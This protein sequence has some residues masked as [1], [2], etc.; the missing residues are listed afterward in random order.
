MEK[1]DYQKFYRERLKLKVVKP[2][3]GDPEGEFKSQ[4][5][6]CGVEGRAVVY[7]TNGWLECPACGRSTLENICRQRKVKLPA[8]KPPVAEAKKPE[9]E[10]EPAIEPEKEPAVKKEKKI[11]DQKVKKQDEQ[12]ALF[13]TLFEG[14]KGYLEIRTISPDKE[15]KQ[16]YYKPKELKRLINDL[17][18][19]ENTNIYFGVCPRSERKGDEAHIKEIRALWVDLDTG[20]LEVLKT[21]KPTPSM[22]I[23][24]GNGYHLYWLLNRIYEVKNEATL[25]SFKGYTKGLAEHL[26][27]D[28]AFDLSRVL[29]VPGTLNLKD[30]KAKEVKLVA[31][32][33]EKRYKLSQFDSFYVKVEPVKID[34]IQL[35]DLKNIPERLKSELASDNWFNLSYQGLRQLKDNTRT[36]KDFALAH[37]LLSYGYTNSEIGF[38]LA[39]A[40]YNK[41]KEMKIKYLKHTIGKARASY[42]FRLKTGYQALYDKIIEPEAPIGKGFVIPERFTII[43]ASDGEGKTCL[44][45][46]LSYCAVL[47][48]PLMG[49]Y[50]I[51]KPVNVLYCCGENSIGDMQAKLRKQLSEVKALT[52]KDVDQAMKDRLKMVEP[53]NINFSLDQKKSEE[54]DPLR[55]LY[56][57]LYQSKAD[58]V[59]FDP[60]ADFIGTYESL[61][62]DTIARRVAQTLNKISREFNCFIILTSHFKKGEKVL[63]DNIFDLIHGSKYWTNSAATQIGIMRSGETQGVNLKKIYMK[64]KTQ[65]EQTKPIRALFNR[66]TLWFSEAPKDY[67]E[68][69]EKA[70]LKPRDMV[71]ILQRF[72]EG[73]TVISIFNEVA[74]KKLNIGDRQERQ[75]LKQAIESGLIEKDKRNKAV[76]RIPEALTIQ[77]ELFKEGKDTQRERERERR[78]RRQ[79]GGKGGA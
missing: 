78:E 44:L 33:P 20:G 26:K 48:I 57:Y 79:R 69:T 36:G 7:E 49:I 45:T 11:T 13:E 16:Y 34:D 59:I 5:P 63:P 75:L 14:C 1:V 39:T 30:K 24:S 50:P 4:C 74:R 25:L 70:K 72:C 28:S 77:K 8:D 47:G 27:G 68:I 66:E 43:A 15:V 23:S 67:D 71:D 62:T 51:P 2:K 52:D 65:P 56:K 18:T 58:I 42:K 19:F 54:Y 32:S 21:F 9:P 17:K 10:K 60:L 6:F 76:I 61:D 35:K 41:D 64:A 73:E 3:P 31:F 40:P 22:I 46:Q 12:V 55:N 37:Y 38:I 53:I 29:R